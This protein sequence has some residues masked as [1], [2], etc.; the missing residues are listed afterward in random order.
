MYKDTQGSLF[1]TLLTQDIDLQGAHTLWKVHPCKWISVHTTD[2]VIDTLDEQL[3]SVRYR[4]TVFMT[5]GCYEHL[6]H[7]WFTQ[8][9]HRFSAAVTM[10][11]IVSW[12]KN[13][14][15]SCEF[16][17]SFIP[18]NI[19][20]FYLKPTK[21]K[22]FG[23]IFTHLLLVLTCWCFFKSSPG[24]TCGSFDN[25]IVMMNHVYKERFPKV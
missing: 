23:S 4:H 16:L 10:I 12:L 17:P 22:Y 24:R 13:N 3:I 19:L 9:I 20:H 2:V 21:P 15:H 8:E 5:Y 14:G 1:L 25:E 11:D 18:I 6:N 7:I